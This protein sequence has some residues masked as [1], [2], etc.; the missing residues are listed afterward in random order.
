MGLVISICSGKYSL[1]LI[2][3]NFCGDF[4]KNLEEL[5]A[6]S[7]GIVFSYVTLFTSL[8]KITLNSDHKMI[9]RH[10]DILK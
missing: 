2:L 10:F 3:L 4:L 6:P 9:H 5:S 7:S 8:N 1:P